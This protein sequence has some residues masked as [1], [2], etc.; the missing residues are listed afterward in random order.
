MRRTPANPEGNT[1]IRILPDGTKQGRLDDSVVMRR[2][3]AT[4]AELT[5][6]RTAGYN[7]VV[8]LLPPESLVTCANRAPADEQSTDGRTSSTVLPPPL[9]HPGQSAVP[10]W[11]TALALMIGG[12]VERPRAIFESSGR[13]SKGA[14]YG[15][16]TLKNRCGVTAASGSTMSNVA[17]SA[18][19]SFQTSHVT[20]FVVANT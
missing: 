17:V 4:P 20:R 5:A 13:G 3:A 1:S 6:S 14:S 2:L 18:T 10:L 19:K 8:I 15:V 7:F 11:G 12:T 16:T 9:W